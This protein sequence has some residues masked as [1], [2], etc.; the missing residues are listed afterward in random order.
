MWRPARP[1]DDESIVA[2]V[3]RLYAEDPAGEPVTEAQTRATLARLRAEPLRGRA[4]VLEINGHASGYA[5]L[6]SFWSNELGGEICEIDELYVAADARGRGWGTGLVQRL[7]ID[8]TLWP[9]RPTAIS[10]EVTPLNARARALY[11]RLGFQPLKN[12]GMRL[13]IRHQG[14]G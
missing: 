1:D 12:P 6:I 3:M 4:V 14:G 8:R 7:P 11:T 9:E 2:L 5:L 10:L 13:R